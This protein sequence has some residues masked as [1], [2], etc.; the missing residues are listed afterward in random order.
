MFTKC[1]VFTFWWGIPSETCALA[2]LNEM[3]SVD[4][5][6]EH[7]KLLHNGRACG[8]LGFVSEMLRYAIKPSTAENPHPQHK[9]AFVLTQL[10]N[11]FF[12]EGKIPSLLNH[13]V[14]TPVYKKGYRSDTLNYRPIAVTE[15]IMRLYAGILNT[16]LLKFTEEQEARAS[17]QSGFRPHHST[18]HPVLTLQHFI[19]KQF[20]SSC[21]LFCCFLDL[22]SAY[23]HVQRPLLCLPSLEYPAE[24]LLLSSLSM[25]IALFAVNLSGRTGRSFNFLAG[26]KQGCPLSPTLFGL[27]L[28]GVQRFLIVNCPGHGPGLFNGN[29]VPVLMYADD[30]ALLAPSANQLQALITNTCIFCNTL[31]LSISPSKSNVVVFSKQSYLCACFYLYWYRYSRGHIG[32]ISWTHISSS[33]WIV[34]LW[35]TAQQNGSCLG[36]PLPSV[37]RSEVCSF[38][39]I[40][41]Q[42]LQGMHPTSGFIRLR[43]MGPTHNTGC[44][45]TTARGLRGK[46]WADSVCHSWNEIH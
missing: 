31:G 14:I 18:L 17:A 16:R 35:A 9:L 19:D 45:K 23:D 8:S 13:A 43:N 24:C 29:F 32:Q 37:C 2:S 11:T 34:Q 26:V 41:A 42:A 40:G 44:H 46:A 6:L 36:S 27:F 25:R 39:V 4:E 20:H 30:I 22:K 1:I 15:P 28:D 3:I 33:A 5:V 10:L 38:S 7:L 12:T 21:P